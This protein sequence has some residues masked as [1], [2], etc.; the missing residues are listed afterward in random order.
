[1]IFDP[2]NPSAGASRVPRFSSFPEG[3]RAF[4]RKPET[5]ESLSNGRGLLR[6]VQW[7]DRKKQ[8]LGVGQAGRLRA[9][10]DQEREGQGSMTAAYEL[11]ELA[12]KHIREEDSIQQARFRLGRMGRLR[13][14]TRSEIDKAWREAL[15]EMRP[16][17][18][19]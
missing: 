5:K 3:P 18:G 9:T 12:L 19:R 17:V 16:H 13:G 8:N 2:K 10:A 4:A 11:H 1:M 15:E 6:L 7:Q 14:A